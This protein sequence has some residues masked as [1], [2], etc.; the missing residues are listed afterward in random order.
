[1]NARKH[2]HV[3][4]NL[5]VKE[6]THLSAF[7]Q[8]NA[9]IIYALLCMN[10]WTLLH[11]YS[12]V[13]WYRCSKWYWL[14]S[15]NTSGKT[16]C[17]INTMI[18]CKHIIVSYHCQHI[19]KTIINKQLQ[20]SQPC[21]PQKNTLTFLLYMDSDIYVHNCKNTV[22]YQWCINYLHGRLCPKAKQKLLII[23]ISFLP[24]LVAFLHMYGHMV[25]IPSLY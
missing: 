19:I 22:K 7:L 15:W 8:M 1:M 4:V 2:K 11:G 5:L 23:M 24:R 20:V 12:H 14:A 9:L 21:Q 17:T 3:Q 10:T 25:V 18:Y 13:S 6:H 16:T